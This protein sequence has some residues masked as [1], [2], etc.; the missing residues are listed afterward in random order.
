MATW[1]DFSKSA[2]S[3]GYWAPAHDAGA[4][5]EYM[6]SAKKTYGKIL[7]EASRGFPSVDEYVGKTVNGA[8]GGIAGGVTGAVGGAY[9]LPKGSSWADYARNISRSGFEGAVE[10][11][12]TM[13]NERSDQ[14]PLRMAETANG[15]L[16]VPVNIADKVL[17]YLGTDGTAAKKVLEGIRLSEDANTVSRL[18][19]GDVQQASRTPLGIAVRTAESLAGDKHNWADWA[20]KNITRP[21]IELSDRTSRNLS[22]MAS[23]GMSGDQRN[24]AI[25]NMNA[26]FNIGQATGTSMLGAAT[27]G[28]VP[29]MVM[30]PFLQSAALRKSIYEKNYLNNR[31]ALVDDVSRY[32]KSIY[33]GTRGYYGKK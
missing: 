33:D 5:R 27:G 19:R 13:W 22:E 25:G 1:K 28:K 24:E 9:Y 7:E 16:T 6:D 30:Y 15:A 32:I 17:A 26:A 12:K 8:L 2:Q 31:N 4:A 3:F 11:A 18:Q 29:A 10:G 23:G 14:A 20:R 21:A